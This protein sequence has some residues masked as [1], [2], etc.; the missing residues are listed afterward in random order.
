MGL[1]ISLLHPSPA[2]AAS[3][4]RASTAHHH[5]RQPMPV[6]ELQRAGMR[7]AQAATVLTGVL[8][9]C[10]LY[11]PVGLTTCARVANAS[12]D[13]PE[14]LW[15]LTPSFSLLHASPHKR[16]PRASIRARRQSISH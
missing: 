11:L 8:V 9:T 14:R 10:N 2:S 13:L 3:A 16:T 6:N 15:I 4:T 7:T 5:A 12:E 1:G